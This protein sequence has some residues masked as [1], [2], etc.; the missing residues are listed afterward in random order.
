LYLQ[1]YTH[2]NV[3]DI[4][5]KEVFYSTLNRTMRSIPKGNIVLLMGDFNA[6][7]GTDN[8]GLEDTSIMGKNGTG[9]RNDN[10]EM[11]IELCGLHQLKIGGTQF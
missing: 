5:D 3:A 6:K 8:N 2:T 1:C 11:M 10:G 7:V 9:K 4:E